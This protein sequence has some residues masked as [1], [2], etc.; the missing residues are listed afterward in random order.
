MLRENSSTQLY[1]SCTIKL[2]KKVVLETSLSL[3]KTEF[4]G[5]FLCSTTSRVRVARQCAPSP[6]YVT[7]RQTLRSSPIFFSLLSSIYNFKKKSLH[8]MSGSNSTPCPSDTRS[9]VAFTIVQLKLEGNPTKEPH[10]GHAICLGAF[11]I[12]R[13]GSAHSAKNSTSKA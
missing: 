7:G 6:A 13:Y 12:T 4:Q 5:Q 3:L 1:F 9:L 10:K 2:M 11:M 8:M